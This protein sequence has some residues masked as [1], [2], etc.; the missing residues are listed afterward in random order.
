MKK[1]MQ[2]REIKTLLKMQT[3]YQSHYDH[4][5]DFFLYRIKDDLEMFTWPHDANV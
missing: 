4:E 5:L 2:R 3:W 1:R